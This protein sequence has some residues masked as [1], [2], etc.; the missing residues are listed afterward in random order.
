MLLFSKRQLFSDLR[1]FLGEEGVSGAEAFGSFQFRLPSGAMSAEYNIVG[2]TSLPKMYVFSAADTALSPSHLDFLKSAGASVTEI[3]LDL[4]LN[5][6]T[7]L[8]ISY[9]EAIV[10]YY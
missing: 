10:K 9:I 3:Q 8:A 7:Q 5:Q 4:T 1:R 6:L 2:G